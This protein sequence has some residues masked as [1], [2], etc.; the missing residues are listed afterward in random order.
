MFSH[1]EIDTH[2]IS[3]FDGLQFIYAWVGSLIP[4]LMLITKIMHSHVY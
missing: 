2:Q 3:I 1:L 4:L